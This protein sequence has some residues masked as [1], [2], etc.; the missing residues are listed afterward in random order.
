M[1]PFS[2]LLLAG[3]FSI[4][5]CS[6]CAFASGMEEGA[7]PKAEPTGER[8]TVIWVSLDGDSNADGSAARPFASITAARDYV[9]TIRDEMSSDIVVMIKGSHELDEPVVLESSDSGANG[10]SIIYRGAEP[11]A[12]TRLLGGR[13][14]R[15][16]RP[17]DANIMVADIPGFNPLGT[18]YENGV[19][20]IRARYP[21]KA[22]SREFPLSD[23][24]YLVST[25][26][27]RTS[28]N[29]SDN[30]LDGAFIDSILPDLADLQIKFWPFGRADW[31]QTIR[32]IK[33]IDPI[34]GVIHF[35][36]MNSSQDDGGGARYYL[37]NSIKFLDQPGEYYHDVSN[38]L[39]YYWPRFDVGSVESEIVVP[40]TRRIFDLQGR[41]D[42]EPVHGIRIENLTLGYTNAFQ[43][44]DTPKLFPWSETSV[45][46]HGV[47]HLKH[48][49]DIHIDGNRILLSGDCGIY[50]ERSNK[51]NRI[52]RNLIEDVGMSGI[53]LAYH[54]QFNKFPDHLN[55]NN[56]IEDNWIRYLGTHAVDSAG[57]NLWG[58]S[59]N[60]VRHCIIED[61]KRY[62]ISARGPFT[63]LRIGEEDN[64]RTTNRPYLE[65]NRFEFLNLRRL[66]Q[67]SGDVGGFH[68]SMVSSRTR[69]P[70]N[71]FNQI[72]ISSIH[73]HPS[74]K[75]VNPNGIFLDY[76]EG[77]VNQVFQNIEITDVSSPFRTNRTD[78]GHTYINCSWKDGFD[79][80]LMRHSEIGVTEAFPGH[81]RPLT[82]IALPRILNG[83]PEGGF[84]LEWNDPLA[85]S[86]H[87]E[88]RL[89]GDP[90]YQSI[91]AGPG[92]KSVTLPAPSTVL[93]KPHFRISCIDTVT[94]KRSKGV[95]IPA[96]P[97]I[98][99]D[100]VLQVSQE[101]TELSLRLSLAN[102]PGHLKAMHL[103]FSEPDLP[104]VKL[105]R[106]N[107]VQQLNIPS[108]VLLKMDVTAEDVYSHQWSGSSRSFY[109]GEA[110]SAP[111]DAIAHWDFDLHAVHDS[112]SIYD[113]SGSGAV[114]FVE[115]GEE[116]VGL[117]EQDGRN[118]IRLSG[119]A[120]RLLD[121]VP[122]ASKLLDGEFTIAMWI[123]A[124]PETPMHGR[125]INFGA[126]RR[127]EWEGWKAEI[128]PDFKPFGFGV[129]SSPIEIGAVFSDPSNAI[130][131]RK[132]N[133]ILHE[134]WHHFVLVLREEGVAECW[135]DGEQVNEETVGR[136]FDGM[137]RIP[138]FFYIGKHPSI[139]HPDMIWRGDIDEMRLFD[140]ALG[141][142]E[143][144]SLASQP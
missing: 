120:L 91:T 62:G 131:L 37:Q 89:E 125:V 119:G 115:G 46:N 117:V 44:M 60:L 29:Y 33:G 39:L 136:I 50:L 64:M 6:G 132:K 94:G 47:I 90:D 92:L 124:D 144:L 95:V 96:S 86:E 88:I 28:L 138:S 121:P 142:D 111:N 14:V 85:E 103:T 30:D 70:V 73:A 80:D 99:V 69:K 12:G 34:E 17:Y 13:I 21:N 32:D 65:G 75:D 133:I 67:D 129:V 118:G 38:G 77:V 134:D 128:D 123:K 24:P 83:G 139:H 20:A 26:G 71:F 15:S 78:F 55:Y 31:H 109:H 56:I 11:A 19:R 58:S 66:C 113:K 25:G 101:E 127:G 107:P 48:S 41:D 110:G 97:P 74:M 27:S 61:G 116:L 36:E 23:A 112:M 140:R 102:A 76:T 3:L 93:K 52:S 114:L 72:H 10:F 100:S 40:Q 143:I 84:I 126:G 105:D 53:V 54:R 35:D 16:W 108:G 98:E 104:T 43:V 4:C 2:A 130:L 7:H 82:E 81:L 87:L 8:R 18:L 122:L 5:L 79:A 49:R 63:Q 68:M 9:R 22:Y 42:D 135:L 141:K 137:D 1:K 59:E 45:G 106:E 57:I 51:H